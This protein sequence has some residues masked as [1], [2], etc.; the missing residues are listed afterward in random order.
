MTEEIA[1]N[2]GLGIIAGR[3]AIAQGIAGWWT[4]KGRH[5]VRL[6]GELEAWPM[7][8]GLV[9][10]P[11]SPMNPGSM[12]LDRF[13]RVLQWAV[14]REVARVVVVSSALTMVK[15]ERG[16]RRFEEGWHPLIGDPKGGG[17]VE[18]AL[19]REGE[20]YRAIA[21][22]LDA[23]VINPTM[24]VGNGLTGVDLTL[25]QEELKEGKP[26]AVLSDADVAIV[27]LQDVVRAAMAALARGRTG[28]R[29]LVSGGKVNLSDL[30]VQAAKAV[31]ARGP[32]RRWSASWLQEVKRRL[33]EA[34]V[35]VLI[36]HLLGLEGQ[37]RAMA[38]SAHGRG[39]R[40]AGELMVEP[41][42]L[43]NI[44][45]DSPMS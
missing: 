31:G 9:I 23:V 40:C 45:S 12:E 7:V 2:A 32:R 15:V 43:A 22:G 28:R 24:V 29:Y 44:A 35:A 3:E 8:R 34:P 26:V 41:L 18:R 37:C 6:E 17:H 30:V 36:R 13:R 10:D 27:R 39:E 25:L 14:D 20:L 11:G 1:H 4:K 21:Q 5:S 33:P 19:W 16:E 38:F 42:R